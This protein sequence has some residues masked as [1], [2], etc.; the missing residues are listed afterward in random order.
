MQQNTQRKRIGGGKRK[1]SKEEQQNLREKLERYSLLTLSGVSII[2]SILDTF[3]LLQV[4]PGISTR[5]PAITLFLLGS[6]VGY[7]VFAQSR[8][9][10]LEKLVQDG[11][12]E[13]GDKITESLS[14]LQ[15]VRVKEFYDIGEVYLHA[16]QQ[17]RRAAKSIDD[18]T[19]AAESSE[20]KT[21]DQS[22]SFTTYRDTVKAVAASHKIQYREVM[23]FPHIQRVALAREMIEA[24]LHNYQL[25]H[26]KLPPG[27]PPLLVFM[28]IDSEEVILAF[29]KDPYAVGLGERHLAIQDRTIARM[30]LDYYNLIW[31]KSKVIKKVGLQESSL[32]ILDGI[33]AELP[34]EQGD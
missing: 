5:L 21:K 30:F 25:R 27:T 12:G 11:F 8:A 1:R 4:F 20:E 14:T 16:A 33:E 28:V 3:G 10:K 17:M 26:Y 24:N 19:W 7:L 34:E 6:M 32:K 22:T 23:S 13:T 2:I 29:Y 18:L 31:A 9:E 15:S